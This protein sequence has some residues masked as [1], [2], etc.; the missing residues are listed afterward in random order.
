ME[1]MFD[2]ARGGKAVRAAVGWKN[3][4][5]SP[6]FLNLNKLKINYLFSIRSLIL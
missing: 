5:Y 1:W 3:I 2:G 6:I 4:F